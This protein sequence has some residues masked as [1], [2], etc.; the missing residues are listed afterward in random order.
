[1]FEHVLPHGLGETVVSPHI[2]H[3]GIFSLELGIP[4]EQF[5][6]L[7]LTP[8]L[9]RTLALGP[10]VTFYGSQQFLSESLFIS[11]PGQMYAAR[12]HCGI[13]HGIGLIC[14]SL[15]GSSM[16]GGIYV[17]ATLCYGKC[18]LFT[19]MLH[20][21]KT[22]IAFHVEQYFSFVIANILTQPLP[23]FVSEEFVQI[24]YDHDVV[25]LQR[26]RIRSVLSLCMFG[27]P[28]HLQS[29]GVELHVGDLVVPLLISVPLLWQS[30]GLVYLV[31]GLVALCDNEAVHVGCVFL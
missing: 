4:V 29:R 26:D 1:M 7:F 21:S 22:P 31:V 5:I 27:G 25:W 24:A 8:H 12:L 18:M 11:H 28:T 15:H 9:I 6:I 10:V 19:N 17:F 13:A 20:I 16:C 30:L 3:P 23:V 14:K 2:H